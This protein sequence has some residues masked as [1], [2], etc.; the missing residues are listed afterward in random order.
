MI[1]YIVSALWHG[2]DPGY[3]F[4]FIGLGLL[5]VFERL[6]I[7]TKICSFLGRVLPHFVIFI[8]VKVWNALAISYVGMAFCFGSFFKFSLMHAALG[9]CL[10]YLLPIGILIAYLLP[11]KSRRSSQPTAEELKNKKDA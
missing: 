2:I 10:H 8:L 5:D 7:S 4:F 1:S 3:I 6:M 9:Y 11:K